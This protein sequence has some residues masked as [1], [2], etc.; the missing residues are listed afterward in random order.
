VFSFRRKP[1]PPAGLSPQ[2]GVHM[3]WYSAPQQHLDTVVFVH[4][5]LGHFLTSWGEFPRLLTE[6][7]EL[8]HLDILMY[9]YRTGWLAR[10]H[11]LR[12]E[13]A[14]LAGT[15]QV[16]VRPENDIVLV[17]HS[18]GGLIILK[19]LV[20]R[21]GL[22]EAQ[23]HPCRAITWITLFASPLN[24]VWLAG[25]AKT[26]AALPLRILRSLH[27]HLRD[28]AHGPFI[29]DLME[30]VRARIYE[31]L[32]DDHQNRKIPIRIVAA[33][34]DAAV[35][36]KNRDFALAPYK[37]P[38]PLQLDE[39][40]TSVKLPAS[41]EEPKYKVLSVDLQRAFTRN[42]RRI[43]ATI[44]DPA[45]S[46]DDREIAFQELRRRYSK[47]IRLRL[48]GIAI[49]DGSQE[50]AEK[51]LLLLIA[52]YGLLH[53]EAVFGAIHRAATALKSRHKDWR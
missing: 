45:T 20:D 14:H 29:D 21:M 52:T 36:E 12:L 32:A 38:A 17:G 27:K 41:R 53:E 3:Q 40:H 43:C 22:G 26:W 13:G 35:D 51:E 9:G 47:L 5:I 37:V 15:L 48:S 2:P 46:V 44:M 7:E 1:P 8:P 39:T 49:P 28:M 23:L 31:P 30:Q 10:H 18:M 16:L 25:L 19:G 33:T 24:G 11:E 4:G 42:F 50:E 6:D 34:R